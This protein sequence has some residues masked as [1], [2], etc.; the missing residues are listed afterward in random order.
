MLETPPAIGESCM[1]KR[2]AGSPSPAATI[3][4][5]I[6]SITSPSGSLRL[7]A[8]VVRRAICIARGYRG[9]A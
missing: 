6:R 2:T 9:L 1:V 8:K 4:A 5:W 7:A 3:A